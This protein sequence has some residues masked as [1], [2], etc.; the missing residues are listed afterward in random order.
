MG[1]EQGWGC[2]GVGGSFWSRE[3]EF[4]RS[5]FDTV[6]QSVPQNCVLQPG[7]QQP[8]CQLRGLLQEHFGKGI[9]LEPNLR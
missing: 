2:S 6:E 8:F 5:E 3:E 9:K 1:Q 4:A 7:Q